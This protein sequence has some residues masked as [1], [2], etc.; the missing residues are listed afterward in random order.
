MICFWILCPVRLLMRI[1]PYWAIR[2]LNDLNHQGGWKHETGVH[3]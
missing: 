3:I 1:M 2:D